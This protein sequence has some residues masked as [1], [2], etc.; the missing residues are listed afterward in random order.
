MSLLELL[1][2]LE[3]RLQLEL[4]YVH[5]PWRS[6]DQKYFVADNQKARRLAGWSPLM[7]KA[8]GLED[9]IA[10]EMSRSATK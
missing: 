1:F 4:N 3:K 8:M 6:N 10:W 9:A 7:S 5:L 2:H